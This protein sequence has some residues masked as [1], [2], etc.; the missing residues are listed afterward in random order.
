MN[1]AASL[2]AAM[3]ATA[4]VLLLGLAGPT[5]RWAVGVLW[6]ASGVAAGGLIERVAA[7]GLQTG[8]D[9][10]VLAGIVFSTAGLVAA[11]CRRVDIPEPLVAALA[12]VI[13]LVGAVLASRQGEVLNA[14]HPILVLHVVFVAVAATTLV[15]GG[16]FAALY[17]VKERTLRRP[18][19]GR[20]LPRLE[21]LDRVQENALTAGFVLL[22]IGVSF[23]VVVMARTD[24]VEA[25]PLLVGTTW[26]T[27]AALAVVLWLRRRGWSGHLLALAALTMVSVLLLVVAASFLGPMQHGGR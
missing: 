11:R 1:L 15:F 10:S 17:L 25:S 26:L 21:T 9:L 14:R 16:V 4:A 27:W 24:A 7:S 19:R 18:S 23:G 22:T 8:A 3:A 6:T 2:A 12:T 20:R 13:Y 5:R